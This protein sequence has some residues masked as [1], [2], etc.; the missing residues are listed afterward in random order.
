MERTLCH[1]KRGVVTRDAGGTRA[2]RV[3]CE[4]CGPRVVALS[5]VRLLGRQNRW[6]Y[7]FTCPGCGARVRK[8]ADEAL[9]NALRGAGAAELSVPGAENVGDAAGSVGG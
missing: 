1:E 7:A 5:S 9:R 8:S 3:R 6:E 2:V 4:A